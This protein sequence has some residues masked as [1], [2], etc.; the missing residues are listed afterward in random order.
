VVIWNQ[1]SNSKKV[2]KSIDGHTVKQCSNHWDY[3]QRSKQAADVGS[4]GTAGTAPPS[5]EP[6]SVGRTRGRVAAASD[7]LH[8]SVSP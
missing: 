2:S 6:V 4:G 1:E 3:L 8:P 7:N 5:E